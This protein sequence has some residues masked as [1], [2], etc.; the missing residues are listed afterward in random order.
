MYGTPPVPTAVNAGLGGAAV[1]SASLS[2]FWLTLALLTLLMLI[3]A[4]RRLMPA[5]EV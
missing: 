5:R 1:G 4:V 2:W 3:G